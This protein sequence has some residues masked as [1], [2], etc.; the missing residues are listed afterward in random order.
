MVTLSYYEVLGIPAD[1]SLA[2]IKTAYHAA[3]LKCHPDKAQT[4][5]INTFQQIQQAWEVRV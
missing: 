1:A 3:A 2:E 4:Q 5:D